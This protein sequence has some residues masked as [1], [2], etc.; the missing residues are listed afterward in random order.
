MPRKPRQAS[1]SGFYHFINRGVNKKKLFHCKEDFEFYKGLLREYKE[2]FHVQI[3]H[4]CLMTNHTHMVVYSIDVQS[5]GR[6]AHFIQRRYAYYYCKAHHWS[7]QVFRNRYLSIPI[8]KD[9][10]LLECG[11]YVERN[12][13]QARLVK[14]LK[15]YEYSSFHFYGLGKQDDLV[16]ESPLFEGLGKTDEERRLV[17]QFNILHDRDYDLPNRKSLKSNSLDKAGQPVPF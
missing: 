10:Y 12:P 3:H 14:D 15:D 17:Y 11:R 2:K 6:F 4:Y 5:L 13:L 9:S 7:E 1:N 8:E 16:T